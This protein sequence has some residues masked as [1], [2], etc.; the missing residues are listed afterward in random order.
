MGI[1]LGPLGRFL[2]FPFCVRLLLV[3]LVLQLTFYFSTRKYA[4]KTR[5][6]SVAQTQTHILNKAMVIPALAS[7]G[8]W[9]TV[10]PENSPMLSPIHQT[11]APHQAGHHL[12]RPPPY[13]ENDLRPPEAS[14]PEAASPASSSSDSGSD[15]NESDSESSSDDSLADVQ[16]TP[17][18]K[19]E[20]PAKIPEEKLAI[21]VPSAVPS[22][23][24]QRTEEETGKM[25]WNL[26]SFVNR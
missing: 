11:P 8:S 21:G 1:M 2:K 14:Q 20:E 13:A 22:S 6:K 5:M 3:L 4:L 15:S 25:R 18:Q 12:D 7:E 26:A 23:P 9:Q 10:V 16:P 24:Q 19:V 17:A